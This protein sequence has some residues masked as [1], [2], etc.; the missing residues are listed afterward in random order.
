MIPLLTFPIQVYRR[1]LLDQKSHLE[2]CSRALIEGLEVIL[3]DIEG[4]AP[5]KA[6]WRGGQL[7]TPANLTKL[8][9]HA[10]RANCLLTVAY[11]R[12]AGA[13]PFLSGE[14]GASALTAALESR[15]FRL[16]EIIIRDLG[17][18]PYVC[19]ADGRVPRD[20]VFMPASLREEIEKVKCRTNT[21]K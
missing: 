11:L 16:A 13:W 12:W 4:D 19:E 8:M 15:H 10:A 18:C 14:W 5:W 2:N 7:A 20:S 1:R 9:V 17:G 6:A 21:V 3:Q